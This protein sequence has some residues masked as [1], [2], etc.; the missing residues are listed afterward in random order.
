MTVVSDDDNTKSFELSVNAVS[1]VT[2]CDTA[3]HISSTHLTGFT[4][5]DFQVGW[6]AIRRAQTS[7]VVENC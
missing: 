7:S 3:K 5:Q 1:F 6:A 2:N 4:F